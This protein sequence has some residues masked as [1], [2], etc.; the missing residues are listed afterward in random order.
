MSSVQVRPVSGRILT[1]PVAQLLFSAFDN[2]RSGTLVLAMPEDKRA[3]LLF[4]D[5]YII[6]A[7]LPAPS[8]SLVAG[9]IPLCAAVDGQWAFYGAS[10]HIGDDAGVLRG[11]VDPY[12]VI[13]AALRGPFRTDVV[14]EVI[15]RLDDRCVRLSEGAELDRFGLTRAEW[16][17]VN[18]LRGRSWSAEELMGAQLAP[19]R[20]VR[21]MLYLLHMTNR[22]SMSA[23]R[24]SDVRAIIK[25]VAKALSS[26]APHPGSLRDS[27]PPGEHAYSIRAPVH[28]DRVQVPHGERGPADIL[29]ADGHYRQ[30]QLLAQSGHLSEAIVHCMRATELSPDVARHHALMGYLLFRGDTSRTHAPEVL[31]Y[32]DRALQ[33]DEGCA[34]TQLYRGLAMW[35]WGE[36]DDAKHHLLRAVSID[37][38]LEQAYAALEALGCGLRTA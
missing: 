15:A 4:E 10:T 1:T 32:L 5:G 27:G 16:T 13:S 14:D 38:K 24:T 19:Y 31:G 17:V 3:E 28:V 2:R 29:R 12:A 25:P 36:R 33:L 18:A 6:G 26:R 23:A 22:L 9:V 20:V 11:H 35:Q 30:A 37:P 8:L 21:R 34:L 7:R